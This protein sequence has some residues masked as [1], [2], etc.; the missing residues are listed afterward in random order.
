[1]LS[2]VLEEVKKYQLMM[3]YDYAN[4]SEEDK[5]STLRDYHVALSVEQAELLNEVSWK[6]W[7]TIESQKPN[8]DKERVLSEWLDCLVFLLDQACCLGIDPYELDAAFQS[9]M[10]SLYSRIYSGYSKTR[11]Q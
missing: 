6:P 11:N 1:M 5:L 7:R 4:M 9:K 10:L 2:Q 8:P 3:G